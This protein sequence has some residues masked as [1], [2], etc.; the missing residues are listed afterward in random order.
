MKTT[1][2]YLES[3]V[4]NF[5]MKQSTYD[6][7]YTCTFDDSNDHSNCSNDCCD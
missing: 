2:N 4:A 7:H 1:Q 5:C 6:A 3:I